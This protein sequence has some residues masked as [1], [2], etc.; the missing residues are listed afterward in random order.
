MKRIELVI[1]VGRARKLKEHGVTVDSYFGWEP[2]CDGNWRVGD[3]FEE[4]MDHSLG[5]LHAYTVTELG[6]MLPDDKNE[7]HLCR[8][9]MLGARL[10]YSTKDQLTNPNLV[11]DIL[12]H[13]IEARYWSLEEINNG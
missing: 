10:T 5:A 3:W 1:D 12:I 4:N 6:H 7:V 11:A 8:T 13:G 9:N 2:F